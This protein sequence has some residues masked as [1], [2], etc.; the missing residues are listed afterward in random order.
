MK[1]DIIVT[2][3]SSCEGHQPLSNSKIKYCA[4]KYVSQDEGQTFIRLPDFP[5]EYPKTKKFLLGLEEG[6]WTWQSTNYQEC[7]KNMQPDNKTNI[8]YRIWHNTDWDNKKPPF[9][10][11]LD[12]KRLE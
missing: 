5:G 8:T 2:Q 12:A 9:P 10:A 1:T 7:L 6:Q 11:L 4:T 3:I